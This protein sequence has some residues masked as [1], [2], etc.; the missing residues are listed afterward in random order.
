MHLHDFLTEVHAIVKPRVYLEV[1]VQYG[2]SLNRA[3]GAEFAIGIDPNPLLPA[4]GNQRIHAV[5]SDAYFADMGFANASVDDLIDFGFVDGLHHYEQA[6]RDFCNIAR[7]TRTDKSVIILDDV[8]PR[9]QEEAAREQCPGDW[10]GD[11]WK[12]SH[13]LM[14]LMPQLRILEV[15]TMPTGTLAVWNLGAYRDLDYRDLPNQPEVA[16][17]MDIFSVPPSTLNRDYAMD[18]RYVLAELE[19]FYSDA[20]S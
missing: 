18:P 13:I 19:E 12:V 8:L 20:S 16:D 1:G 17:Y 7:Y 5:T 6:L 15:N 9:N 4:A 2:T 14:R 3:Y 11:V 10:T